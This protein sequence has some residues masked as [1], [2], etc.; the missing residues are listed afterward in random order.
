MFQPFETPTTQSGKSSWVKKLIG[1]RDVM[2]RVP[3]LSLLYLYGAWQPAFEEVTEVDFQPG[4][5]TRTDLEWRMDPTCYSFW[6]T[7]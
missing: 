5:P 6:M 3:P 4:L 2:F 7:L 1:N